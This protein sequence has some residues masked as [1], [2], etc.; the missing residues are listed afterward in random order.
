MAF[1]KI[2]IK[3][4]N[5]LRFPSSHVSINIF[6]VT[7]QDTKGSKGTVGIYLLLSEGVKFAKPC[8]E[9]KSSFLSSE[10]L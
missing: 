10:D 4:I 2:P 7:T 8:T 5:S 3:R 6:R 9:A 1:M